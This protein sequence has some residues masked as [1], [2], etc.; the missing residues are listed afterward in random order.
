MSFLYSQN[1]HEMRHSIMSIGPETAQRILDDANHDN[2]KLRE[3][4][5]LRYAEMMSNGDWKLSPEP[6]V[7]SKTGR[8]LNG[9]HRL[10]AVVKSG[11]IC[12]F[13]VVQG[14]DDDVFDVLDRG[15]TRTSADALKIDKT[16]AEV[17]RLLALTECGQYI[18]LNDF[19]IKEMCMLVKET[20]DELMEFCPGRSK[21]FTSAPFRVAVI[22]HVMMGADKHKSFSLYRDL[23][24]GHVENLPPIGHAAVRM[25]LTGAIEA[26]ARGMSRQFAML[27]FAWALFDP[28]RRDSTIV[29]RSKSPDFNETVIKAIRNEKA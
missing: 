3:N 7:V 23:C 12:N 26:G 28:Q 16:L 24:L 17:G 25:V 11:V 1:K 2:R 14:A 29:R 18:K 19:K 22:A 5:V 4:V 20:H 15:A 6:I 13:S 21:V 10:H 9:Q 27:R 8:L